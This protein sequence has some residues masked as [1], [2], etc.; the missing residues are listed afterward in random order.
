MVYMGDEP[1]LQL[2]GKDHPYSYT[3]QHIEEDRLVL[4]MGLIL[5]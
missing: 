3:F 5:P 4:Q 1:T 2:P